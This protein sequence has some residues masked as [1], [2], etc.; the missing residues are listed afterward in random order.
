M[1]MLTRNQD[2][3]YPAGRNANG[4]RQKINALKR[5]L[6]PEFESIKAGNPVEST[7]KKKTTTDG[8]P[9]STPRKRKA[10]KDEDG[11]DTPKKR[12][13]PK[14]NAVAEPETE[15]VIKDEPQGEAEVEDQI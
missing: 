12:G 9:K 15:P 2:A 7:P 1:N 3:P 13:R 11:E 10:A 6:Q 8:T 5:E 14:K 4:F